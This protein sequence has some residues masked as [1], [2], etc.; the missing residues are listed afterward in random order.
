MV[1][2]IV[3]KLNQPAGIGTVEWTRKDDTGKLHTQLLENALYFPPSPVNI[4]SV[5]EY[6]KQLNDEEGTGIDTEMNYSHF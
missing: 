5:T 6:A 4:M 1:A 2:M 3:G